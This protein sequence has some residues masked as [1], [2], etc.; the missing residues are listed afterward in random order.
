EALVAT[1][2]MGSITEQAPYS[3]VSGTQQAVASAYK[4]EEDVLRFNIA[5]YSGTLVID[6]QLDW[7][8]YYGDVASD[9]GLGIGT[10]ATGNVY[11]TGQ[12]N[13]STNIATAGA[14]QT[15]HGGGS[16]DGF[17]VKFSTTGVRL[18][19]TYY[20]GT[21]LDWTHDLVCNTSGDVYVAGHTYSATGI[22]TP[23]SFQPTYSSST[24]VYDAFLVKFN[25][26][27]TRLWGTYY[28]DVGH[29]WAQGLALDPSGNIYM[30]GH[31][32]NSLNLAT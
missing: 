10:D 1:T 9:E 23:G 14:H 12:T 28:G 24:N 26:S 18:W 19:G 3:Y 27:G 17:I 15:N 29:D 30:T 20:G 6:P 4:L 7:A 8:T 25:S 22:A 11:M 2:P 5:P 32:L 13:S 16:E 21:N 31:T